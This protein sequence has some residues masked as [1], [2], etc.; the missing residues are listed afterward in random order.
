MSNWLYHVDKAARPLF[1]FYWRLKLVD[2]H[3]YIPRK[4][5]AIV[6]SN[7]ACFLDPWLIGPLS[8]PRTVHWLMTRKWY[9]KSAF[10][11]YFFSRQATIPVENRDPEATVKRVLGTLEK[12]QVVGI[13]PEGRISYTGK[14]NKFKSGTAYMAARSGAPVLPVGIRGAFEALPRTQLFPQRGRVTATVGEPLVF[15]G[16]P[17][18]NPEPR[19]IIEFRDRMFCAVCRLSGQEERIREVLRNGDIEPATY[20]EESV[21]ATEERSGKAVAAVDPQAETPHS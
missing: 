14:I 19:D 2:E 10:W 17:C 3:G 8:F 21:T 13:F 9:D 16:S 15:P 20:P 18:D 1:W 6:V 12:G 11:R 5:P 4:G 7:H